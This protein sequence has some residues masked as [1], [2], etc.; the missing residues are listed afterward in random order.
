MSTL[1]PGLTAD[2]LAGFPNDGKRYEVVAGELHMAYTPS[3]DHQELSARV[4]GSLRDAVIPRR[5]GQVVIGPVGV[6]FSDQDLVKPD[7]V[8]V[9]SERRDIRRDDAIHGAPDIVVEVLSPDTRAYDLTEKLRLYERYL[10]PEYWIFDPVGFTITLL[11]LTNGRYVETGRID[12]VYRSS[13]L[14]EFVID[15]ALLFAGLDDW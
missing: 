9:R 15:P 7:I 14:L 6:R 10:V 3:L 2:E 4:N 1:A 13:V 8:F 11:V 12:G 5:L